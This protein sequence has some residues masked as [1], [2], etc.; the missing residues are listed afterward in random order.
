MEASAIYVLCAVLIAFLLP[1]SYFKEGFKIQVDTSL[2]WNTMANGCK[3][4]F[5]LLSDGITNNIYGP[6]RRLIN[7]II[8]F[9]PYFR[10]RRRMSKIAKM[11]NLAKKERMKNKKEALK[12]SVKTKS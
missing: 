4:P 7:G 11:E 3:K 1:M 12:K 5:V 2:D 8:P 10:K 6:T 9:K